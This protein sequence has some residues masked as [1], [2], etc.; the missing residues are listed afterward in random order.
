MKK[1]LL[2][3]ELINLSQRIIEP[4]EEYRDLPPAGGG[5]I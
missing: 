4:K 5:Y 2:V 3:K 1:A